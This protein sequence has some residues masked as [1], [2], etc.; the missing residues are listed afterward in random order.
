MT[1]SEE[2]VDTDNLPEPLK[3]LANDILMLNG[4]YW[5]ENR[6]GTYGAERVKER[7][8]TSNQ[9]KWIKKIKEQIEGVSGDE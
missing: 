8:F 2:P 3:W 4:E 5:L 1:D 9:E 6:K 7:N